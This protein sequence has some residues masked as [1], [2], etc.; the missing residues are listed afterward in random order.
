MND[1]D[2]LLEASCELSD[3]NTPE[4][5][6]DEIAEEYESLKA[7]IEGKI[8][9]GD[10][11]DKSVQQAEIRQDL[12]SQVAKLKEELLNKYENDFKL[13]STLDEIKEYCKPNPNTYDMSGFDVVQELKEILAKHEGMK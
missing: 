3:Y 6:R 2:R 4:E 10:R 12:E 5:Y 13:K 8:E 11:W 7:K 1:L 9:K